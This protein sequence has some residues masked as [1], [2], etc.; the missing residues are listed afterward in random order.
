V[1][2]SRGGETLASGDKKGAVRLWDTATGRMSQALPDDHGGEVAAVAFRP[3]GEFL[4]AAGKDGGVRIWEVKT[5][6]KHTYPN[7]RRAVTTLAYSPDG[8]Y[9]ASGSEDRQ[10]IVRDA[11]G[12]VV[13]SNEDH[14]CFVH[15]VAYS[16]DGRYFSTAPGPG[17]QDPVQAL[18]VSVSGDGTL[19]LWDTTTNQTRSIKAH[20]SDV[21]S[22]A[23]SP[24]GTRLASASL[25]FTVKLWDVVS[26]D[27][28]LSLR[29]HTGGVLGLAFSPDGNLLAS[30]GR[31]GTVR[32]WDA[33][34]WTPPPRN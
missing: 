17:P 34:P 22:V 6:R 9:L 31:D 3:G 4:A 18:L 14:S 7:H 28:V 29:G 13:F 15:S 5:L 32:I 10:V 12:R 21:W 11:T 27:E 16:P 19:F 23:F 26:G 1:A 24:D 8:T 30:A 33:R 25:D 2:F 20:G